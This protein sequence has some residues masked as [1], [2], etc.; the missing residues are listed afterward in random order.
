M[1]I[2]IMPITTVTT[3]SSREDL[4]EVLK[5]GAEEGTVQA[6]NQM[7]ALLGSAV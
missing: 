4:E 1:L 6:M 3:M 2:I 5:M 7:D